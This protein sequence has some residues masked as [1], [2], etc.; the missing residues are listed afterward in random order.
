[1]CEDFY[2]GPPEEIGERLTDQGRVV[3]QDH[4]QRHGAATS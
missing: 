2:A 3:G 4:A 1:L